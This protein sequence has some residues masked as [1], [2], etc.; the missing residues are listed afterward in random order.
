MELR[1]DSY[2]LEL[3]DEGELVLLGDDFDELSDE[4]E[5]TELCELGLD[6]LLDSLDG[7]DKEL[8]LET[9]DLLL[10]LLG[11]DLLLDSD[12]AEE[13]ELLELVELKDDLLEAELG[14]D[15]E[16]DSDDKLDT[17]LADDTEL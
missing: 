3:T 17:E 12:E 14:L 16:L 10:K 4:R 9:D 8:G 2:D 15:L 6:L 7:E 1:L 11:L 5:L 13:T